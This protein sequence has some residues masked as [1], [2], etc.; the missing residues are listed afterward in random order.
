MKRIE[1]SSTSDTFT[2][3]YFTSFSHINA[4][5]HRRFYTQTLLQTDSFTH[6][7]LY[8]QILLHT[9]AFTQRFTHRRFYTQ[10]PWHTHRRFYTQTLLHRRF[11]Y[12]HRRFYTTLLHTQI[13]F[14]HT[15]ALTHTHRHFYTPTLL[16]TAVFTHRHFYTQ[17]LLHRRCYTH[18]H[19]HTQTLL[20]TPQD[21]NFTS[22]LDHRP[23]FCPKAL[24][25]NPQNR[26]FR[27]VFGPSTR[28]SSERGCAGTLKIAIFLQFLTID[29]HFVK[30]GCVSRSFVATTPASR[31]KR[32]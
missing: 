14:T 20:H 30:N 31:E 11:F 15:D 16:H 18:T 6:K 13:A 10:T 25:G 24:R 9:D 4:F 29:P 8:T 28:I 19:S 26:N 3:S 5:T 22:I 1:K 23:A 12:T 7:R 32:N 17:T 27:S 2:R 21:Y